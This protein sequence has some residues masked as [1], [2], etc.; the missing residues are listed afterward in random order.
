MAVDKVYELMG[1]VGRYQVC[2]IVLL[3]LLQV[4]VAAQAIFMTVVGAELPFHWDFGNILPNQSR[5]TTTDSMNPIF[6]HWL[7]MVNKTEIQTHVHFDSGSS[8]VVGE[9]FLIGDASY[10]VVVASSIYFFGVLVGVITFGQ[11][12][13]RFGRKKVYLAG[14]SL[15]I[16]FGI[17]SGVTP[18][19]EI[20]VISRFAVG[21]M[22][23]GMSLSAFVLLQEYVAVSN[24][25]LTGT[26]QS[27]SFA[28]GISLYALLGYLIRP[29]RILAIVINIEGMLI[30]L[31]S[32][33]IP[34]SPHWLYAQGRWSEAK[35]ILEKFAKKHG[36]TKGTVTLKP[37][38]VHDCDHSACVLDLFHHRLLLGRTLI[39]MYVW[40]I[41]SLVYYG[42]TLNVGNMGGNLYLNI[43]LSGLAE[44]PSYPLCY[45]L[46]NCTWS[47][48]RRTLAGFLLLAGAAC[49]VMIVLPEKKGIGIYSVV[50]TRYFS[51]LGKL[52][53]S[54]A[55]NVV[56]VYTSELYPTSVR[57]VGMG[58]CSMSS[59]LGGIIAPFLP[60]LK[61]INSSLHFM[62]FGVTGLL[63][64]II[65]LL[66]PE[67]LNET[68][69]DTISDLH[70]VTY[71]PLQEDVVSL[72]SQENK[73]A[74]DVNRTEHSN[75]ENE[76]DS[77]ADEETTLIK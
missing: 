2:L 62:I 58:I 30:L 57:N 47:G 75:Y 44:L 43:A 41:C 61:S 73:M 4:Y 59:R 26:L 51:I 42:L 70:I 36:Q 12:S 19:Y 54:A 10:K 50:N 64:G 28:V 53:I 48:R 67:T 17:V 27:L 68:L 9:W 5:N 40:F 46:M 56:Y 29:W 74:S 31:P 18:T 65:S 76:E 32:F 13:D 77:E 45:F 63:A 20:F 23:G 14:L 72:Q 15:D 52:S 66:L 24:W 69:L 8:S 1:G 55:F 21:L 3:N 11:L 7:H 33:F 34:E 6:K 39:M 35:D 37:P 25:A 49:L 71:R 22:N 38:V 16:L 60:L